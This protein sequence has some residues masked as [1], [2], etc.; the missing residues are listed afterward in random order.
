[1]D[2]T[3]IPRLLQDLYHQQYQP[4]DWCVERALPRIAGAGPAFRCG[5]QRAEFA[6]AGSAGAWD[7]QSLMS[8]AGIDSI[9][10][11]I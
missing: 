6:G 8:H 5:S 1:M 3:T 4:C 2:V 11:S 10:S 9:E 7:L